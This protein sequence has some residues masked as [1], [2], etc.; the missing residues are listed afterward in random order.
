MAIYLFIY[1]PITGPS[2]IF[3]FSFMESVR[4]RERSYH[5]HTLALAMINIG[6]C[7]TTNE[8]GKA[9]S[10]PDSLPV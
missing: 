3:G 5:A 8:P 6:Q 1:I 7:G 2:P 4:N 10:P 9:P